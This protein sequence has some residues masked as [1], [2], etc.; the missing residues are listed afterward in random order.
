MVILRS[1]ANI[2]RFAEI[3]VAP[4]PNRPVEQWASQVFRDVCDNYANAP[5]WATGI[6]EASP[7]TGIPL[8]GLN[9]G[10]KP[11]W[12]SQGKDGPSLPFQYLGGQCSTGYS[13]AYDYTDANGNTATQTSPALQGP[14]G[15]IRTEEITNLSGDFSGLLRVFI[16]TAVGEVLAVNVGGAGNPRTDRNYRVTRLDGLADDCGN[17]PRVIEPGDNPPDDPGDDPDRRPFIDIDGNIVIPV[18]PIF[19]DVNLPDIE[20]PTDFNFEPELALDI[21]IGEGGGSS[22]DGQPSDGLGEGEPIDGNGGEPSD[23]DGEDIDFGEPPE[24]RVW[25]GAFLQVLSSPGVGNIPGSGPE[26]RAYPRVVGNF[27]LTYGSLRGKAHRVES[28]WTELFRPSTTLEVTGSRV[29]LLRGF[30]YR[31]SPISAPTCPENPCSA[32]EE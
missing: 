24:G 29:N 30:R 15:A 5:Q 14:L 8:A 23:G 11:W 2:D 25:V 32:S 31:V 20:V 26:N 1:L 12:D 6:L 19:V 22:G 28:Q 21:G 10:C 13:L 18:I 17:G 3:T 4:N 27:S 16:D 9:L 7:V